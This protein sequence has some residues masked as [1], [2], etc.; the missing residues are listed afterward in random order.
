MKRLFTFSICLSVLTGCSS[1]QTPQ[2]TAYFKLVGKDLYLTVSNKGTKPITITSYEGSVHLWTE[3]VD[4]GERG[5]GV[6]PAGFSCYVNPLLVYPGQ[7]EDLKVPKGMFGMPDDTGKTVVRMTYTTK[8]NPYHASLVL[9]G[10]NYAG[11]ELL[12]MAEERRKIE[13]TLNTPYPSPDEMYTGFHFAWHWN[14]VPRRVTQY[15]D[16]RTVMELKFH[17]DGTFEGG[18]NCGEWGKRTAE[19]FM[20]WYNKQMTDKE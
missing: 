3:S 5:I 6:S 7:E 18:F 14:Q 1:F 17:P 4:Y 20:Q 8:G 13:E 15:R 16:G 10:S 11:K 2:H 19:E 12:Q 9:Q